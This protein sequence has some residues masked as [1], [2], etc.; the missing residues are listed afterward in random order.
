MTSCQSIRL[1]VFVRLSPV[2]EHNPNM[3][4]VKL[5]TKGHVASFSKAT[6]FKSFKSLYES[7]RSLLTQTSWSDCHR[8]VFLYILSHRCSRPSLEH[9]LED[10]HWNLWQQAQL[11]KAIPSIWFG[12]KKA[13]CCTR[14]YTIT[15]TS[16]L[17]DRS[18]WS[19]PS[20]V[21]RWCGCVPHRSW[22]SDNWRSTVCFSPLSIYHFLSSG[23]S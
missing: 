14:W 16:H 3:E 17:T 5:V 6:L 8:S 13:K 9:L 19:L 11:R 10:D 22:A 12:C 2:P 21:C 20:T 18:Y 15:L 4:N 23:T 7:H 1:R